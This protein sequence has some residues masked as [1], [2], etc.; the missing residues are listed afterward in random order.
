MRPLKIKGCDVVT[1]S[2]DGRR[3]AC[4]ARYVFVWDLV[5]R[6]KTLKSHPL[7]CP[8]SVCFS[9]SGHQLAVKSTS[10]QIVIIDPEDG[11]ILCDFRN[12]QDGEGSNIRSSPCGDFLIDGSW[13]GRLSVRRVDSGKIEFVQEFPGEMISPRP[14]ANKGATGSSAWP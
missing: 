14:R 1:F 9:P 13:N 6:I 7:S 11:I 12:F 2:P 5:K 3:L 4:F 10:G 8:A